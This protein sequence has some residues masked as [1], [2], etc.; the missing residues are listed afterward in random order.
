M[1]FTCPYM[2]AHRNLEVLLYDTPWDLQAFLYHSPW[3][4]TGTLI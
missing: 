1:G 3:T 4:F 2:I